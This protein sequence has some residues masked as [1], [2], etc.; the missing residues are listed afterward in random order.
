MLQR[1]S[2]NTLCSLL[3]RS[4]LLL[5]LLLGVSADAQR[6]DTS[7]FPS[8]SSRVIDQADVL[9]DGQAR[10]LRAKLQAHEEA[11]SNQIVVLTLPTT[12]GHDIASFGYQLGRHW[13]IGTAEHDN[14]VILIV[15]VQDRQMRIEVGYGLEGALPDATASSIIRHEIT[16][17]FREGDYARGIELGIDSIIAAI[18]GEYQA[19]ESGNIT[20]GLF[21]RLIQLVMM[22]FIG[23]MLLSN[24]VQAITQTRKKELS[25]GEKIKKRGIVAS[26]ATLVPAIIVWLLSQSVLFVLLAIVVILPIL[27]FN[28]TLPGH[29]SGGS[30]TGRGGFGGGG[31]SFSGGGGSFG[32]GGAS[33]GW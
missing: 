4:L 24:W 17:A 7:L 10:R 22:S 3:M 1:F 15:A 23:A 8:L 27:I 18:A 30:R 6:V 14:G 19:T 32:G 21:D 33:G 13:G 31:G 26:L 5:S 25:I 28:D 29:A 11:T 2:Q 12:Q 9:S 16:P 20:P